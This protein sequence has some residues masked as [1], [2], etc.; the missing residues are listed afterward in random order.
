MFNVLKRGE[1]GTNDLL[2]RSH[3]ELEGHA[4]GNGAGAV[5]SA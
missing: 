4:A 5:P 3:D 1:S 2:S